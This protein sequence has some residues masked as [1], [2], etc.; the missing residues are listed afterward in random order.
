MEIELVYPEGSNPVL[1]ITA[2]T[3]SMERV[4]KSTEKSVINVENRYMI[5]VNNSDIDTLC[6]FIKCFG[7]DDCACE[8]LLRTILGI[9]G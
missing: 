6:E 3:P 2:P 1:T 7:C 5:I 9:K 8:D 4:L